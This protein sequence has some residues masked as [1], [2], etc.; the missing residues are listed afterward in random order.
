MGCWRRRDVFD[1]G[2]RVI[3]MSVVFPVVRLDANGR[4]EYVELT[5]RPSGEAS[6]VLALY[7]NSYRTDWKAPQGDAKPLRKY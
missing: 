1:G 7:G 6:L 3:E 4:I 5:Q 2:L